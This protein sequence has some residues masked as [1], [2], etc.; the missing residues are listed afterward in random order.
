MRIYVSH[1][2]RSDFET[3]I[4]QPLKNS[5]LA[6]HH[7]FVLPHEGANK[8][9]SFNTKDLLKH[10][11]CDLVLA[12]VSE[13]ATGQGIELAWANVYGVP[14]MCM[15]KNGSDISGSLKFLTDTFIE[16]KDSDDLINKLTVALGEN[17][18]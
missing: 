2:R 4:Y 12:E 7:E 5:L 6:K 15:Y 1:K 3:N 17:I 14:I 9:K 11:E 16:Y 10:K 8:D 13:A 18:A